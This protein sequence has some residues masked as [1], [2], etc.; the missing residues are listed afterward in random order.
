M[1]F[2]VPP[3]RQV[4]AGV[5]LH[6]PLVVTFSRSSTTGEDKQQNGETFALSDFSGIWIYLSLTTADMGQSLAP[7]QNDLF[8][9][10]KA[11]SIHQVYREQD[12][13]RPIVAYTTFPDV[14]IAKPGSYRIK[15]AVID[16]NAYESIS[17]KYATKMLIYVRA[18]RRAK[19]EDAGR[20]LPCLHSPVFEVVKASHHGGHGGS[21]SV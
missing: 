13:N 21:Q 15:V 8:S 5:R 4:A 9:G 10:R 14:A 16:M 18:C 12:G 17:L 3:P 11:D 7:P 1:E 19:A 2:A 6:S 20:V